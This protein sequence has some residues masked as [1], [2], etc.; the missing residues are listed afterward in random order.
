[1]TTVKGQPAGTLLGKRLIALAVC[2]YMTRAILGVIKCMLDIAL[3]SSVVLIMAAFYSATGNL[4]SKG[5]PATALAK[6][7]ALVD[8][9]FA[10]VAD[11]LPTLSG[12]LQS[13]AGYIY[14]SPDASS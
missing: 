14:A 13:I 1:M 12:P 11:R 8:P 9:M 7:E 5:V 6:L 2:I 3:I 10:Q 4:D